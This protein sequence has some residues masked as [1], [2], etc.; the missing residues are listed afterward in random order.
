MPWEGGAPLLWPSLKVKFLYFWFIISTRVSQGFEAVAIGT[1]KM[2]SNETGRLHFKPVVKFAKMS[3]L[4]KWVIKLT[5][6]H[7]KLF[8]FT[9]RVGHH[10]PEYLSNLKYLKNILLH[11][12]EGGPLKEGVDTYIFICESVLVTIFATRKI[13]PVF[14]WRLYLE[15][16]GF[17][18]GSADVLSG[19]V[20]Y[21][22][23]VQFGKTEIICL[24][25]HI[26]FNRDNFS[27]PWQMIS[28]RRQCDC[29]LVVCAVMPHKVPLASDLRE[30]ESRVWGKKQKKHPH[31]QWGAKSPENAGTK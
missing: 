21:D 13:S 20:Q 8:G 12:C 1:F 26:C 25:I 3:S 10:S 31:R 29:H 2:K 14:A 30:G 24:N 6:I 28:F 27:Q 4:N 5:S 15:A 22:I 19:N 11:K 23:K 9:P 7:Q 17:Q 16:D 18:H